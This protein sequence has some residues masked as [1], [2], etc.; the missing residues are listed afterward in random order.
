MFLTITAILLASLFGM[1]FTI[2]CQQSNKIDRLRCRIKEL[3]REVDHYKRSANELNEMFEGLADA[4]ESHD[5]CYFV[6]YSETGDAIVF[7]R[8]F[9][10]GREYHTFIKSFTDEDEGFNQ[11]EAE[12]L[13]EMLNS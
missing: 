5:V 2:A 11:R 10:S 3:S 1:A 13:C 6:S 4:N 8:C 9:N 12:E 7:R